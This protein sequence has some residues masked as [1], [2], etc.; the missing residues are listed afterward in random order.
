MVRA[1]FGRKKEIVAINH[2]AKVTLKIGHDRY[3]N[4]IIKELSVKGDTIE[5]VISRTREMLDE[6]NTLKMDSMAVKA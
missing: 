4:L 3:N 1:M 2:E 5:E 6:F